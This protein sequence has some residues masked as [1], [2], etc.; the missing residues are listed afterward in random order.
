M[1][2]KRSRPSLAGKTSLRGTGCLSANQAKKFN[3]H[4]DVDWREFRWC[5]QF[6]K[7]MERAEQYFWRQTAER[8]I[9]FRNYVAAKNRLWHGNEFSFGKASNG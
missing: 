7:D 9:I 2:R 8:Q 3:Q 4:R 1:R 5:E 6:K